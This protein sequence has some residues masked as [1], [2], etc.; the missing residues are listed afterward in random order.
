MNLTNI[1]YDMIGIIF[2]YHIDPEL[3]KDAIK[4]NNNHFQKVLQ[5][6]NSQRYFYEYNSK[7]ELG[8]P[9][10]YI[11]LRS[12]LIGKLRRSSNQDLQFLEE[13]SHYKIHLL[14]ELLVVCCKESNMVGFMILIKKLHNLDTMLFDQKITHYLKLTNNNE[15]DVLY[16][17]ITY[18]YPTLTD[19]LNSEW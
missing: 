19:I 8:P 16:S 9:K 2:E 17:Y 3:I 7:L 14:D 15:A 13:Y 18:K 12:M 4:T 1:S 11:E 5:N 6:K 10:N